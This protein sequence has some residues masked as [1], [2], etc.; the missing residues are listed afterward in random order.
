ML[1]TFLVGTALYPHFFTSFQ[2]QIDMVNLVGNMLLSSACIAYL[3]AFTAG[4]RS[5][6]ISSW[7][8]V[9]TG[10]EI[11]VDPAFSLVRLLA[12]PVVVREWNAMGLPADDFSTENGL[13]ATL[14]RRWPLMIDPQGQANRWI[15]N[16][17]RENKLQIIK[18]SQAD[19][20]RTLENAIRFGQPVLLE[21]V[22][23]ELDPALEP[24]LLKQTFKKGGQ[25]CLRLGDTDV[26]YSDDFRFYITTKLANPVRVLLEREK[27]ERQASYAVCA[28][29]I[30]QHYMPEV[31]VKVTIIN[32]TVTTSGLEDQ[33]LVD[34]VRFERPDLEAKKDALIVSIAG[35]KRQLKEIEDRILQMLADAKGEILDDE[36]LINSLAA[37]KSTSRAIGER[38]RDAEVTTKEISEVCVRSQCLRVNIFCAYLMPAPCAGSRAL[39]PRRHPRVDPL[40]RRRRSRSDRLHVSVLAAGIF[41]LVQHAHRKVRAFRRPQRS[42]QNPH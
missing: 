19:F 30:T 4:F 23:E 8:S 31:C 33:L 3:G 18:L 16:V 25:L 22:E 38:M 14:G 20:L 41:A 26:P 34:V 2:L 37:S 1:A 36:D 39:P 17:H 15:K 32:F 42:R 29:L 10:M 28:P 6:L 24:V 11:P 9:A 5:E 40:F 35:D 13:F 21:N 7:V 12:D 27:Y